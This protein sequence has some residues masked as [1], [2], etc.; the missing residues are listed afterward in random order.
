MAEWQGKSVT[1]NSP[2][3]IPKG[4]GGYG[5]KRKE[6]F[7]KGCSSDGGRVKRI[8]FGDKKMG[9]HP[10][11]KSRKAS[12]CARSGGISGKTDRCSANYWARRDW[13][14]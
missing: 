6:V 5:K 7:V 9:K 3:A 13:N 1:L 2:R 14:C 11:D 4:A 10:G 8:T 12:Y